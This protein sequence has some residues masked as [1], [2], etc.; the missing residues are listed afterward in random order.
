MAEKPPIFITGVTGYMGRAL[1][2]VLLGRGHEVVG[3][4]R[5][6][7]EAKAPDGIRIVAGDALESV[8]FAR[9]IPPG[10]TVVHLV[11]VAHPS[12]AKARQFREID[13]RSAHAVV[14]ACRDA[15]VPH[16]VYLS[17]AQ[18]A[19][20][21]KA[22]IAVRAEAEAAIR[23]A[24]LTATFV[25]PWYVLGPG[26]RWPL[27][28]APFYWLAERFPPTRDGARRLGLV[29]LAQMVNALVEAIETPPAALRI[30]DVPAIRAAHRNA[31]ESSRGNGLVERMP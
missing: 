24:G 4:V 19:P 22:Y 13:L 11:G 5:A 15:R 3:L 23:A 20:A 18:P 6:G 10:A 31:V 17:V 7:S 8:T 16:L 28:L 2:P 14:E 21:M 26:H 30:V 9:Q 29:T 27:V 12:P 25:R 1:V